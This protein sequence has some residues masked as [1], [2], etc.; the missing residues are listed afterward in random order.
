MGF[1]FFMPYLLEAE[2][3]EYIQLCQDNGYSE[4]QCEL[5]Y[6]ELQ[7]SGNYETTY[8]YGE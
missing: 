2:Y 3:A 7:M 1:I 4:L 6:K 5:R 8:M